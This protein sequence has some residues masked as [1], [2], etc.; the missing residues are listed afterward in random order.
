MKRAGEGYEENV[1]TDVVGHAIAPYGDGGHLQVLRVP[2]VVNA[3]M[4]ARPLRNLPY[5]G[6]EEL[7]KGVGYGL[8]K[9]S[10]IGRERFRHHTLLHYVCLLFFFAERY[11]AS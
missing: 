1:A 10:A 7:L 5:V 11:G 3:D 6:A 8:Q 4:R 2:A 9:G